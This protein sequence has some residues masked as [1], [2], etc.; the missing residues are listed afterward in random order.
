MPIRLLVGGAK[1]KTV[2][3]HL[4][5]TDLAQVFTQGAANAGPSLRT[6]RRRDLTTQPT[7]RNRRTAVEE[8]GRPDISTRPDLIIATEVSLSSPGGPR[9]SGS[10]LRHEAGR[11]F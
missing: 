2:C 8:P 7:R 11:H 5:I 4:S 3:Y 10:T 6:T 9:V 1:I